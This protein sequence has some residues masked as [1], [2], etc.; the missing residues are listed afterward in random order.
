MMRSDLGVQLART[1]RAAQ[2]ADA[3]GA[4]SDEAVAGFEMSRR[5][6]LAAIGA[7]ATVASL[8]RAGRAAA[9]R[10]SR[11]AEIAIV[12]AG[13]AGLV[14][15]GELQRLG[16]RPHLFDANDRVGG[17]CYSLRGFFPG[18]VAEH[19][20]EFLDNLHKVMLGYVNEFGL[21]REDRDKLSGEVFY[22]VDGVDHTEAE[23]I[24]EFRAF[25]PAMHA[26][27]RLSSG[28]PTADSFNEYDVVLDNTSLAEYLQTRGA[29]GIIGPIVEAAY[30]GEYGREIDEQSSLNFLLFIHADRR[31]KFTPFG[32]YSDE[33]F[34]VVEGNDAIPTAIHDGLSRKAELGVALVAARKSSG[35]RVTLT[36]ARGATTFEQTFDA[37]VFAT[38]FSALRD[39][40]LRGLDLPDWK[41]FAIENFQYGTNAKLLVGFDRPFWRDL[42]GNGDCYVSGSRNVLNTWETNWSQAGP[43]GAILTD[44][45]GGRLG[46]R[47]GTGTVDIRTAEFLGDVDAV[48]PGAL[49]NATKVGNSYRAALFH[50][51]TQPL[52][53]GSYTCNQPGYFT[54]IAGNEGKPV[55]SVFFAGEHADSFYSYQGFM[56]GAA[57]SGLTAAAGVASVV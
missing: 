12:G 33:R 35:G 53:Q 6:F 21:T 49:A 44:Y 48:F 14:C 55:G 25:V 52:W 34:H 39:V 43:G 51:P 2:W 16:F 26:D 17:R 19:G 30:I 50:W 13:L 32:V 1:I 28:A 29:G 47:L 27:L 45:T 7:T 8:G 9:A 23:V 42:G 24:D 11:D 22:R 57:I 31:A 20:G 54:T 5:H 40:D 41:R 15:A 3:H 46:E 36:L 4:S 18:Q 37:V 10:P 56:E 38:P